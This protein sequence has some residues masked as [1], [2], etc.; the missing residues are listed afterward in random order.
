MS[1]ATYPCGGRG[2]VPVEFDVISLC[3][4][5][6]GVFALDGGSIDHR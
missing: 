2:D 1:F 5:H 3:A 6:V 4:A